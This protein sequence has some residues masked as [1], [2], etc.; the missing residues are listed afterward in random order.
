MGIVSSSDDTVAVKP[1]SVLELQFQQ[2]ISD[3]VGDNALDPFAGG[4]FEQNQGLDEILQAIM[5]AK[6][7]NDIKGISINNNFI[8]A[9]LAQTQAIR[10]ALHEFKE[11]GKF[12][13]TYGD[14]YM[15]KDYYLASVADS[16][17]L[18]PVGVLDFRGLS[19]EV[20][21][22]KDLLRILIFSREIY[23][24]KLHPRILYFKIF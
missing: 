22:F 20:L 18:N 15:Q 17:F 6:D 2:P 13:Y 12:I 8:M 5:V 21:F 9:G 19:S 24:R 11:S 14:F 4:L 10:K 3:Y 16:V 7:D 23:S 1:N